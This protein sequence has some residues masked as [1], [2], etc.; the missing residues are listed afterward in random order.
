MIV[1]LM[2]SFPNKREAFQSERKI[3]HKGCERE[4]MDTTANQ[5]AGNS[6]ILTT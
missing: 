3:Y 5:S 1:V 6:S 2:I 4:G